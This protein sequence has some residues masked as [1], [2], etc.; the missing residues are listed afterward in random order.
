VTVRDGEEYFSFVRRAAANPIGR[1][2]KLADLKDNSNLARISNPTQRDFDRIEKYRVAIEMIEQMDRFDEA[3][4]EAEVSMLPL[5][6]RTGLGTNVI[7]G[8]R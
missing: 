7:P 5:C 3:A 2:L 6:S 8:D 1:K 4:A